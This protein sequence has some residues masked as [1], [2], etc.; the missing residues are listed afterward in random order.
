MQHDLLEQRW[1]GLI[2]PKRVKVGPCGPVERENGH[3]LFLYERPQLV[4]RTCFE[5]GKIHTAT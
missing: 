5:K 1:T 4:H 3:P 2:G